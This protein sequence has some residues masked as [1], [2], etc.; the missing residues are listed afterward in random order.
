MCN[1]GR[2]PRVV[3]TAEKWFGCFRNVFCVLFLQ[4][5][6]KSVHMRC[7]AEKSELWGVLG[8]SNGYRRKKGSKG[9][10]SPKKGEK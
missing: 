9:G 4:H 7:R 10:K 3:S 6:V 5:V 8:Q 2:C 1:I